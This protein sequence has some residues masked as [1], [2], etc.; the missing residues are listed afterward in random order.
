MGWRC[1]KLTIVTMK[2]NDFKH[3]LLEITKV[4][5]ENANILHVLSILYFNLKC[6][7]ICNVIIITK[8][9]ILKTKVVQQI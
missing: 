4:S 5:K 8:F 6:E 7:I 3:L 1:P 9:K 2:I